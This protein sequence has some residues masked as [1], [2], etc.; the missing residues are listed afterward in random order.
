M[1]GQLNDIQPLGAPLGH[2]VEHILLSL[3]CYQVRFQPWALCCMSSSLPFLP[4]VP[5]AFTIK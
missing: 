4:C 2:L 3:R 5:L 1:T